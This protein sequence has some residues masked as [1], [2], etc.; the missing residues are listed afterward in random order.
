[1]DN[2]KKAARRKRI[3]R[4]LLLH[5]SLFLFLAA[6]AVFLGCPLR[7]ITGLSCPGCG[8]SRAL[9]AAVRL[10]FKS[11]FSFHPLFPVAILTILYACHK[12]AWHLP[13]NRLSSLILT[14]SVVGLFAAVWIF[15]LSTGDPV[16][17]PDFSSSLLFRLARRGSLPAFCLGLS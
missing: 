16:V 13:G 6:Y 10:D 2:E 3:R 9:L 7:R 17:A 15:R 4:A 14:V 5:A 12:R 8:M 1:M 11:A